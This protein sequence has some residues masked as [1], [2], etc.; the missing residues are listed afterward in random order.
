M[1]PQENQLAYRQADIRGASPIELVITLYDILN[2]DLQ[3]ATLAMD[4]RDIEARTNKLKHALLVLQQLESPIDVEAGEV[5][6]G[7]LRLY[8]SMRGKILEAQIKQDAGIL[9]DQTKLVLQLRAAWTQ[10][11]SSPAP[12]APTVAPATSA[13]NV[14]SAF[15]LQEAQTSSWSA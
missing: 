7:L 5:A 14:T 9:R 1:S 6:R 12:D 3:A 13:R 4:A 8:A 2:A 10:V 15:G 11:N